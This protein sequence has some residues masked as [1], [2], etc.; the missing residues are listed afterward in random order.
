MSQRTLVPVFLFLAAGLAF[1]SVA[2][3]RTQEETGPSAAM[4]SDLKRKLNEV[5]ASAG[6][7]SGRT[8]RV[9]EPELESYVLYELRDELAV[10]LDSVDLE[11][12]PGVLAAT[13]RMEVGEDL[14][15][16][17]P[18]VGPLFEGTHTVF[19]EGAFEGQRGLGAFSLERVRL[20]GVVVP[21]FMVKAL[22]RNLGEPVDLD[23]PF[24]LPAGIQGVV[25][26][27]RS[28]NVVY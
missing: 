1:G 25:L 16:A 9:T 8:L 28:A 6:A 15:A 24:R 5:G 14:S 10:E 27:E 20:D 26:G 18:V 4:A 7:A 19:F 23:A 17:H 21:V 13:V 3:P 22:L 2:V 12:R 11:I